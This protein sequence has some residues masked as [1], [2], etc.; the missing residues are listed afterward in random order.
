MFLKPA[1]RGN[2]FFVFFK[3]KNEEKFKKIVILTLNSVAHFWNIQK[4]GKLLQ[5]FNN[6]KIFR[7][8]WF[9]ENKNFAAQPKLQIF[10]NWVP[11]NIPD[12]QKCVGFQKSKKL[13]NHS[14]LQVKVIETF[15]YFFIFHT[16]EFSAHLGSFL[17]V[18]CL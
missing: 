16:N 7:S 3:A 17:T 4:I 14:T 10:F 1:T 18:F 2:V 15:Q 8:L 9:S 5:I 11:K 13:L 6:K 12:Q